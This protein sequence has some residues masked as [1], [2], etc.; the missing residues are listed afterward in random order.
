MLKVILYHFSFRFCAHLIHQNPHTNTTYKAKEK[1]EKKEKNKCFMIPHK[2]ISTVYKWSIK[3]KEYT[4]PY[5]S[6]IYI[7][8]A[9]KFSLVVILHFP[10]GIRSR[11]I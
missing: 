8:S 7:I 2:R 10:L 3:H 11:I 9:I 4:C 6:Q 5:V 1:Q